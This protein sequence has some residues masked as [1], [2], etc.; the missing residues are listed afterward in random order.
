MHNFKLMIEWKMML[1][2]NISRVNIYL[3]APEAAWQI[4]AYDIC[5]QNPSVSC[6]KLHE[7]N[8]N[9]HQYFLTPGNQNSPSQGSDLI[10]Y[11]NHP[12]DSNF[13]TLH[14]IDYYESYILYPP[15]QTG[16]FPNEYW[17]ESSSLPNV[18]PLDSSVT[19]KENYI[20]H[21]I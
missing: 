3:S 21:T 9:R 10:Q 2:V 5:C 1:L 8:L 17:D 14:F 15:P 7:P 13:N 6:L 18:P 12:L 16:H 11:F 4:L 20:S 19:S